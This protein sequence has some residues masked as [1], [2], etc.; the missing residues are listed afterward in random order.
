MKRVLISL[1]ASFIILALFWVSGVDIER[2][3]EQ[4]VALMFSIAAFL[5]VYFIPGWE[6]E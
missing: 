3:K 4:P 2:G 5:W 1:L 6:K